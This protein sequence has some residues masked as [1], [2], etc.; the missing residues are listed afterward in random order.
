MPERLQPIQLLY[1]NSFGSIWEYQSAFQEG[2]IDWDEVLGP[3]CAICGE[4]GCHRKITPYSRGVIELFPW[5]GGRVDVARF[6]CR[7]RQV[8]FSLLP[9]QLVPYCRYSLE[10]IVGVLLLVWQAREED[11]VGV[12]TALN[13]LVGDSDLGP[14][15]VGHW[16]G[17]VLRGLRRGHPVLSA[18]Y[19]L[20]GVRSSSSAAEG[21]DELAAYCAAFA[22]NR[23][24][25]PPSRRSLNNPCA[26]YANET[27]LFLIGRPSQHR[28]AAPG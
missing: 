24:R 21:L 16:L 15:L 12:G 13:E 26:L 8:T 2:R 28:R 27:H 5:R 6:Q 10:S 4:A 14:Y 1:V 25:A 19:N 9:C 3:R 20:T 18:R 22:G 23:P 11:D 17:L 7:N